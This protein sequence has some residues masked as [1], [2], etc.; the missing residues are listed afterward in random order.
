LYKKNSRNDHC[1]SSNYQKRRRPLSYSRHD[2]VARRSLAAPLR[3]SL[4]NNNLLKMLL[5]YPAV[6]C[7]CSDEYQVSLVWYLLLIE[8]LRDDAMMYVSFCMGL[9]EEVTQCW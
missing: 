3:L 4:N 9:T 1:N 2:A 7:F 5:L 8:L 6:L